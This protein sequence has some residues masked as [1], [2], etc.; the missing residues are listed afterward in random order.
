MEGTQC[1]VE[2]TPF[3]PTPS[4]TYDN[5]NGDDG[6][7]GTSKN[8]SLKVAAIKCTRTVRDKSVAFF[9]IIRDFILR[10]CSKDLDVQVLSFVAAVAMHRN[11]FA[12]LNVRHGLRFSAWRVLHP[13][14]HFLGHGNL[15]SGGGGGEGGDYR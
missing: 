1:D 6:H 10:L 9:I 11:Q 14:R 4:N 15:A 3:L 7:N 12:S 13:S 8:A 2:Y 5:S